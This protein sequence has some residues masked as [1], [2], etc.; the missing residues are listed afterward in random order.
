[1]VGGLIERYRLNTRQLQR[2]DS[3][4]FCL[5]VREVRPTGR[6]NAIIY[7][8]IHL[9]ECNNV[10][11]SQ[12]CPVCIYCVVIIPISIFMKRLFLKVFLKSCWKSK[13]KYPH[14]DKTLSLPLL[15]LLQAESCKHSDVAVS[16]NSVY[17]GQMLLLERQTRNKCVCYP[18]VSS[19][20]VWLRKWRWGSFLWIYCF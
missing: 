13:R 18:L 16:G 5:V 14:P 20:P 1:M 8:N 11:S 15:C 3:S 12:F 2:A 19:G 10:K 4:P 17:F 9:L 6:E 7:A